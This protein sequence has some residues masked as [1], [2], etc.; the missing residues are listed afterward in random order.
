MPSG[1][2][3]YFN[4]LK[5]DLSFDQRKPEFVFLSLRPEDPEDPDGWN[6]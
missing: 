2:M 3:W 4:E 1:F 5:L 6:L